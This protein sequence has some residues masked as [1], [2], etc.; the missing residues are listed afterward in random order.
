MANHTRASCGHLAPAVGA[1]G[2]AARRRGRSASASRARRAMKEATAMNAV[3]KQHARQALKDI[4]DAAKIK[5]GNRADDL[6]RFAGE[7]MAK[8]STVLEFD[9]DE[10]YPGPCS[11]E[12]LTEDGI[13][14]RCRGI[15]E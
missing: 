13:C 14:R 15:G 6:G 5:K 7:V 3:Q 4:W 8:I 10:K 11:H 12:R 9:F 1:P 2:S